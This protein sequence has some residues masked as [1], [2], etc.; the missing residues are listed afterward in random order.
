MSKRGAILITGATGFLGSELAVRLLRRD[1]DRRLLCLVRA[2][3]ARAGARRGLAAL[4][5]ALGRPLTA[6]EASRVSWLAA[7]VE[8]PDL[9][10]PP[11]VRRFLA[12]GIEEIFHC[13][14]STRCDLPLGAARRIN[15]DGVR[16]VHALAAEAAALGR[17]RRLHHVSTAYAAGRPRGRL[18]A[19]VLPPDRPG[20]FR[21]T[22]ER[23]MAEAER[24][25]HRGSAVP[26][27]IYRPSIIVGDS[28]TGRTS[29]WHGVYVLLGL[30]AAGRLPFVPGGGV[31]RLDC[32]PVDYVADAIL[33]L[34]AHTDSAG[35]TYHLTAGPAAL[36]VPDV[37]RHTYAAI[38]RHRCAPLCI[39]TRSVGRI[40]WWLI[41]QAYRLRVDGRARGLLGALRRYLPYARSSSV[42]DNTR[43]SDLLAATG[44]QSP[45]PEDFFPRVVDYA[46]AND[47]GRRRPQ[48]STAQ[49]LTHGSQL[50]TRREHREYREPCRGLMPA[51]EREA[52]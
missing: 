51:S 19:Q 9:G 21:N 32:V 29:N 7:D 20:R 48:S 28:R 25:L 50:A 18:D 45:R 8:M 40:R 43:E 3:S 33:A 27:T 26:T 49:D 14:V 30:M 36:T 37:I 17:F 10:L 44:V 16:T 22:Y 13:A 38:A 35:H 34:G 24:F 52:V 11:P 46:L 23:T 2:D 5:L 41:E 4:A 6:V 47:F 42:F 15:V 39:G 31:A 1:D 12:S